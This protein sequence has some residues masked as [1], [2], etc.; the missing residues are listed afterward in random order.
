MK[1]EKL[2]HW[3]TI[4]GNLG[5][6]GGLILVAIELNQNTASI[7]GSA[8][9][10]WVA[11]NLELN[12]TASTDGMSQTLNAGNLDSANLNQG[13]F[14]EYGLW[15]YSFFQLIQATDYLYKTGSLDRALWQ[16]EINRAAVHLELR[17][18]RQWWDAGGKTQ[19]TPEFVELIES[20]RSTSTR[21]GWEDGRGVL[22]DTA[23]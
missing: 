4:V 16:S 7:Q 8:Y 22:Q 3:L 12:A 17:G 1:T 10:T 13:N 20:T 5:I 18:V 23:Q 14:I 2:A 11:A 6:L 9:Q 21:W 19:L 15:N